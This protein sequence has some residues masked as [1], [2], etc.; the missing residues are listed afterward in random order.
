MLEGDI[1][2]MVEGSKIID[3]ELLGK[4]FSLPFR[5]DFLPVNLTYY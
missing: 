5:C 4:Q 2:E 3:K 1:D